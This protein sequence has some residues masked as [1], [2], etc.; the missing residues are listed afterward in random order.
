MM[1]VILISP[2]IEYKVRRCRFRTAVIVVDM[3]NECKCGKNSRF[4]KNSIPE[5]KTCGLKDMY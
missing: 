4:R 3:D 5:K 2:N 1:A